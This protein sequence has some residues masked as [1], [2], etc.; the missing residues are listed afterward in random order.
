M[1]RLIGLFACLFLPTVAAAGEPRILPPT[2]DLSGPAATQRLAVLDAETG[3]FVGDRTAGATFVSSNPAVATVDKDGLIHA[4]GD[5]E[6]VITATVGGQRAP[7]RAVVTRTKEPFTPSY[8]N[9]VIPVLTKI[10]CNSGACHGALAGK[11]G[12]KLS[13]RGYDP[14]A[15]HFVMTR[16][17]GGRRVNR[18]EPEQSLILLKPTR[19][20]PHG[21]GKKFETDSEE[22]RRL[23]DWIAAGANGPRPGAPALQ[24]IELFPAAATLK[25]K[26]TVRV[27]VRAWY[28]D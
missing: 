3:T 4:A 8:R 13:L 12:F 23:R 19:G 27:L 5:G 16:Q 26:D 9:H 25:P 17:A 14:D 6:A 20:M 2:I 22:Y 24:R 28:S 10:G 1:K 15:D 11:G 21:G 7:A 18:T